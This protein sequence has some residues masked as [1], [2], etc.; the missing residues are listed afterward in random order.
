M[1]AIESA[2]SII[3]EAQRSLIQ[4][5]AEKQQPMSAADAKMVDHYSRVLGDLEKCLE[6]LRMEGGVK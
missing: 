5:A 3:R 4:N 6:E 1:N 2:M